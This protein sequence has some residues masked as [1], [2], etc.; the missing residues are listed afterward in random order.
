MG[1]PASANSSASRTGTDG[2]RSL[3]LRMNA[4]PHA[5]AGPAFH[6]GII[7]GKLNGVMPATTPERLAQRVHVDAPAGALGVLTLEQMR[8]PDRELDHLDAALNIA[9]GVGEGLTVLEGQQLGQFVDVLVDQLD[10]P[11]HHPGPALRVQRR[12]L[13]LRLDRHGDGGVDVGRRAHRHLRLHLAGVRVV[14]I[15]GAL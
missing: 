10:E 7:A 13:L 15:G 12:P 11:H 8:D 5:S 9:A 1:R 6:S 4:L 2:S 3:G 14:H